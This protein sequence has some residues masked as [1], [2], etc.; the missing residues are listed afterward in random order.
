VNRRI[1]R[2]G[3][4]TAG[5]DCPGLNAV[6]RAVTKCAQNDFG[7]EVVGIE[8]GYIGL[9]KSKG[10]VL[11]NRD[12]SGIL[13]TGGTILGTARGNPFHAAGKEEGDYSVFQKAFRSLKIDALICTG[14]DGTMTMANKLFNNGFPVVGVPKTIDNDVMETDLTFGFNSAVSIIMEAID[15][16]HSTAM[17][18]HRVIVVEVMG[19]WVGWLALAAG[20]AGGGDVLL[21]PEIPFEEDVIFERVLERSTHGKRFSIVVVA[22]GVT[23]RGK[24]QDRDVSWKVKLGGVGQYISNMIQEGTGLETRPVI[25]GHL[26][27]GGPPT[28]FDRLLASQLAVKAVDLVMEGNF[29]QMAAIRG[30]NLTSVPIARAIRKLKKVP[31]NHPLIRAA[32]AVG[33]SFGVRKIK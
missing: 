12:V 14:G 1:R 25:L 5:G 28:A 32:L 9:A 17:S 31:L 22:E 6:I 30:R 15:N 20:V 26:Q 33:T 4:L 3:L 16:L 7:I 29:G 8:D 2:I 18:H 10:K 13:A 21:L 23:P 19:R 27:R 24:K 11:T